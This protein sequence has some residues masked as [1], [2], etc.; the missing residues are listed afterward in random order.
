MSTAAADAPV[1]RRRAATSAASTPTAPAGGTPANPPLTLLDFFP[2]E[3]SNQTRIAPFFEALRRGRLS[4]TRC[5]K[6]GRILWPP[7]VVCPSCHTDPLEWVELP[8]RGRLYAFSAV[9][10]G[11]PM[12]MESEVPFAVGLVDLDG[13]PLRLFGRIVGRRWE[14]LKVG[15]ATTTEPYELPD[16]RVFFRFRVGPE[17]APVA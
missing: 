15:D 13:V 5:P 11:A 16:G 1:P 7:R 4:T 12:G 17:R 9:L 6:E 14:E 2:L 10:A 3:G 8:E